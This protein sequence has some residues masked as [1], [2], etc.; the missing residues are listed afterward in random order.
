[1]KINISNYESLHRRLKNNTEDLSRINSTLN[2]F[3]IENNSLIKALKNL[4]EAIEES[5]DIGNKIVD[6]E[7]FKETGKKKLRQNGYIEDISDK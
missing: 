5:M 6:E 3:N 7:K 4:K 1:M 2:N